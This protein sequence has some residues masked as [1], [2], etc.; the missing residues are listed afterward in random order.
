MAMNSDQMNGP[1]DVRFLQ[2]G[3]GMPM[4]FRCGACGE[5][6]SVIGRKM[7]FVRGLRQYVCKG[8]Y[9]PPKDAAK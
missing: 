8:C 5:P 7:Q 2:T 6:R 9:R 3:A 1:A 4:T